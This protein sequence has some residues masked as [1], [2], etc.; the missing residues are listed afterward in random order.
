MIV[1]GSQ[2]WNAFE[3]ALFGS[4]SVRVLHH[5]GCPVL[6]VPGPSHGGGGEPGRVTDAE[7]DHGY[8][9]RTSDP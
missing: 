1:I 2:G 7:T 6:V 3:R 4:V 9:T 5:S 8:G